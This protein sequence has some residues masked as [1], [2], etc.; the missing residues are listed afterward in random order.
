M[1]NCTF[2]MQL[3]VIDDVLVRHMVSAQFPQWA[4]LPVKAVTMGGW[5]KK[6]FRLGERMIVRLPSAA[7]YAAQVEKEHRWL[8]RLA[9]FLPVQIPIP[10]AIGEPTSSYPWKW[11][12][13]RWIEGETAAQEVVTDSNDFAAGVAGFLVALRRIEPMGGPPPGPHNFYRGGPLTTYD[14]EVREAIGILER[15][16]DTK[17]A[18]AI[19]EAALRT[20]WDHSPV[21]I[22][23]DMSVGNLLSQDGELRAVIDFGMLGVGDPACDLS[24]AWTLFRGRSREVFRAMLPFDSGTWIRGRAWTLWKALIVEAGL[25]RT[26]AIEWAQP[27]HVIDE[28]LHEKKF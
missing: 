25:S 14:A 7:A 20:S 18:T 16:I 13:C 24:I 19:W 9:P 2:A 28:V 11:S 6:S 15:R 26:N 22:H 12:I 17:A 4:H 5:D 21:W 1:L 8:P 10:L 3:P 23:G 27:R